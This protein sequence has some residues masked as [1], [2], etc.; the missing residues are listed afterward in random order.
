MSV[1]RA[2]ATVSAEVVEFV[3]AK[4]R[5]TLRR[6]ETAM[7][8]WVTSTVELADLV[9]ETQRDECWRVDDDYRAALAAGAIAPAADRHHDRTWLAWKFNRA[10]RTVR[11]LADYGELRS[12]IAA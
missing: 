4:A 12:I 10:A 7:G 1:A 6:L 8:R 5:D 9:F 11:Q 3:E 2:D